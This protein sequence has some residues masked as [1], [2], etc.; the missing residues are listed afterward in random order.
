VAINVVRQRVD[1]GKYRDDGARPAS[2]VD[3]VQPHHGGKI[4]AG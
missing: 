1:A 2:V 3:H 4:V